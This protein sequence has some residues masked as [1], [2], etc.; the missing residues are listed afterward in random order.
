MTVSELVKQLHDLPDEAEIFVSEDEV[1]I[2]RLDKV[3]SVGRLLAQEGLKG[4][5]GKVVAGVIVFD[6]NHN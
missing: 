6:C 5:G 1:N 4:Q 2:R 3:L